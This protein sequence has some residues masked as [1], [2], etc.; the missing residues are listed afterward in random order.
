MDIA[1]TSGDFRFNYAGFQA[2]VDLTTLRVDSAKDN[3]AQIRFR[4]YFLAPIDDERPG[5][6]TAALGAAWY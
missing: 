5:A 2:T 6:L 1:E 4:L 3:E